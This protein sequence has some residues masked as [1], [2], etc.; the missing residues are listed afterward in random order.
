MKRNR[1]GFNNFREFFRSRMTVQAILLLIGVVINPSYIDDEKKPSG[2]QRYDRD[3][4][5]IRSICH[6]GFKIFRGS[7]FCNITIEPEFFDN[8]T[9]VIVQVLLK[10]CRARLPAGT[11]TGAFISVNCN[12]HITTRL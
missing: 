6:A 7:A 10:E 9:E 11:T 12:L 3:G 4:T 1:Q 2:F 5:E 8:L